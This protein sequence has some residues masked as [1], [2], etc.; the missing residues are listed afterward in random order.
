MQKG[1]DIAN[2][3]VFVMII[4]AISRVTGFGRDAV[5]A[6]VFGAS[7]H[8]DAYL[9]SVT[10]PL[11]FF[12]IAG[13]ALSTAYVPVLTGYTKGRTIK[14]RNQFIDNVINVV[15][16]T[17][18][19]LTIFI[20]IS[21]PML[22]KLIAYGFTG[23]VYALAL[24]LTIIASPL[25][26]FSALTSVIRGTLHSE[27]RF[28][29]A[30]SIG[31]SYNLILIVYLVLFGDRYGIYGFAFVT[32]GAGLSQ[33]LI[34][35]P[36]LKKISFKSTGW[37]L[38]FIKICQNDND[39]KKIIRMITPVFFGA[40]V[41][42]LNVFVDRNLASGLEEGSIAALNYAN[43][44]NG[45]AVGV[46]IL[47]IAGVIFPA[48]SKL[49]SE[50]NMADFLHIL[51]KSVN[52]SIY[53]LIPSAIIMIIL[54]DPIIRII[55]KRGAFDQ[56]AVLMTSSA[57]LFYSIGLLALG[58]REILIKASYSVHDTKTPMT[59]GI[60]IVS[61]NIILNLI[62]VRLMG[63]GGIAL[64]TTISR[65]GG[66]IALVYAIYKKIGDF[67]IKEICGNFL[68]TVIAG[69]AM[70]TAMIMLVKYL[71]EFVDMSSKS[72]QISI[73]AA[74]SATGLIVYILVLSILLII[75]KKRLLH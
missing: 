51:K 64:A 30:A 12:S 5:M 15:L 9:V 11:V 38:N 70:L 36:S 66:L 43:N 17:G 47:S 57:L 6:S 23:E 44:I 42:Q 28:M 45:L 40:G 31:I 72:G 7:I 55:Y 56:R 74:A 24:R 20:S 52:I 16:I 65:T 10:I 3:A 58:L 22:V 29:A 33:I 54:R 14:E 71:K 1:K 48:M 67:G 21:S 4:N 60:W 27:N 62:L 2:A 53:I 25:V 50:K 19:I 63:L 39:I 32:L 61:A 69:A 68:K 75:K 35:L 34:Q 46:F 8:M 18:I 37:R 73:V 49:A 59:N 13:A 26:L 41:W